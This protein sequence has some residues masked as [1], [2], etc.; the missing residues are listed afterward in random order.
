V[1]L[2]FM[3]HAGEV[4]LDQQQGELLVQRLYHEPD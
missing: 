1:T 4:E 2:I 3:D